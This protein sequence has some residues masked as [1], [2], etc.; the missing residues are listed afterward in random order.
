MEWIV[1]HNCYSAWFGESLKYSKVNRETD[2]QDAVLGK[3][4]TQ[5]WG[6]TEMQSL[7]VLVMAFKK[8]MS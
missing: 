1:K 4:S 7:S 2:V 5:S 6:I 8:Q 3:G